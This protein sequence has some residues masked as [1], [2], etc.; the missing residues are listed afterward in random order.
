MADLPFHVLPIR[1]HGPGSARSVERALDRL[2]PDCM[3]LEGPADAEDVLALA[4]HG[5]MTP[6]VA[7][8]VYAADDPSQAVYYPFARFSPEWRAIRWAQTNG[9]ALKFFDLPQWHRMALDRE[10]KARSD[11]AATGAE[12]AAPP[13][14][15]TP[16]KLP[17]PLE[18]EEL[19]TPIHRDPLGE[20]A[21]AAGFD[22][23]ERWWE[24]VVEHR[25]NATHDTDVDLGVFAA[26][27]EAMVALR[28]QDATAGP[29]DELREAF[30]RRTMREAARRDFKT[31]A[32]VCGAFH[33]PALADPAAR[34]KQDDA[35][36]KGL[37]KIKTAAAWVPW[38]HDLLTA[39]SGYGAGVA[40]PGWYDHIF[41]HDTLVLERWMTRIARLLREEDVDCSSAHVIES[42]RLAH[43]LAAM[44]QRPLA[45]LTDIADAARAVFCH[46]SDAPMRLIARKLLV[47]DA[48]GQVPDEAPQTPLKQDLARLQKS[49]R[50]KPEALERILELDLRNPTDLARS[51]LLHRLNL[52]GVKWGTLAGAGAR[53]KGTFK[54]PWKLRWDPLEEI[55]LIQSARFG[56]TVKE[57]ASGVVRHKLAE[58]STDLAALAAM[59][60]TLLLADLPA[61]LDALLAQIDA[62]A[63][64]AADV[65]ALMDALPALARAMRYGT[66]R[67]NDTALLTHTVAGIL[68]RMIAG[69]PPAVANLNDDAAALFSA[70]IGQANEA[71]TLLGD[72]A[73]GA[74][75]WRNVLTHI[76][77]APHTHGQIQG[78]CAR[79]L[80]DAAKLSSDDV[81]T[82]MS[83]ALSRGA[84]PNHAAAWLQG[85]LEHSGLILV[86][87]PKLLATIDDW[88]S[89]IADNAFDAIVPLLRRTFST[90]A[91]PERRQIGAQLAHGR[92][93][94]SSPGAA[95]LP[96]ADPVR[97]ARVIPTLKLIF[98]VSK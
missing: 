95:P 50:L 23:G 10:Q 46:D 82:A 71:I 29:Q 40:S 78:K 77:I 31:I 27:R 39:A 62:V 8:L 16:A 91:A 5:Q 65:A 57:A 6:P 89:Q 15:A 80:F 14:T 55:Q 83:L 37:P 17:E 56:N 52:I 21:R 81:T 19:P 36:L 97:A 24:H 48:L 34:K 4:S 33:A 60:D 88:V 96:S 30:M 69:L 42:V 74:A 11:D 72:D 86:H 51:L 18:T 28:E 85:F 61:A 1:H 12:P 73:P 75:E 53:S 58:R 93:A 44:R 67:Q 32:V 2:R 68:P 43:A 87:D 7:I 98:G 49:L 35:L 64:I 41:S 47:G 84:D 22:D 45:D 90:F 26:I 59:L 3:L 79:L 66:V 25:R 92:T 76:H 63:A 70:R 38:T 20:L 54:E 9:V 13:E 94:S